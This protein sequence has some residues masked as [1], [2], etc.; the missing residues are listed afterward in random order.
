MVQVDILLKNL[1]REYDITIGRNRTF[2]VSMDEEV[3]SHDVYIYDLFDRQSIYGDEL[4][5]LIFRLTQNNVEYLL[6]ISLF[7][8]PLLYGYDDRLLSM[9][10]N[11]TLFALEHAVS[12]NY[13][14]I[15]SSDVDVRGTVYTDLVPQAT[16]LVYEDDTPMSLA[17][18]IGVKDNR[19]ALS[20]IGDLIN[21]KLL[22]PRGLSA[23][24]FDNVTDDMQ[25]KID[26]AGGGEIRDDLS[27]DM[28]VDEVFESKRVD[29]GKQISRLMSAV[30]IGT[31]KR[32]SPEMSSMTLTTEAG[33]TSITRIS[34]LWLRSK[35]TD[36]IAEDFLNVCEVMLNATGIHWLDGY[37]YEYDDMLLSAMDL[38]YPKMSL[39]SEFGKMY[40]KF[41]FDIK[42]LTSSLESVIPDFT[43]IVNLKDDVRD[44]MK[45]ESGVDFDYSVVIACSPFAMPLKNAPVVF[46]VSTYLNPKTSQTSISDEIVLDLHRTLGLGVVAENT[47][48]FSVTEEMESYYGLGRYDNRYLYYWDSY[49]ISDMSAEIENRTQSG[50]V[51]M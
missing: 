37:L 41:T 39:V 6:D 9:I 43:S 49:T 5:P 27:L 4:Y 47:I 30:G 17:G 38:T 16:R 18:T 29:L 50:S 28:S 23:R 15:K 45:L 11:N 36:T 48:D 14:P 40:I 2:D 22:T 13:F 24:L 32:V 46:A 8:D 1:Q 34:D 51:D 42:E 20:T 7:P 26:V 21:N 12:Y 31:N 3:Q 10:D 44:V 33:V 25:T 35:I 19:L